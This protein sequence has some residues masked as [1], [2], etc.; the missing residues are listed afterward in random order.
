MKKWL[1]VICFLVCA[2]IALYSS[3]AYEKN[4]GTYFKGLPTILLFIGILLIFFGVVAL[5]SNFGGFS[6]DEQKVV[7]DEE[8]IMFTQ[9]NYISNPRFKNEDD[10][11]EYA[12]NYAKVNNC[13]KDSE[14]KL[15]HFFIEN[16]ESMRLGYVFETGNVLMLNNVP[17]TINKAAA[18]YLAADVKP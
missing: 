1:I 12:C 7:N 6:S 9:T 5:V 14:Q 4:L 15:V 2:A 16:L 18:K 10:F 3:I 8:S 11:I 17:E 13:P